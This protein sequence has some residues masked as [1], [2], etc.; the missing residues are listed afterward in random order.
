[1]YASPMYMHI[2]ISCVC[3]EYH[4]LMVTTQL[5]SIVRAIYETSPIIKKKIFKFTFSVTLGSLAIPYYV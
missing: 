3:S 5:Q 4:F 2:L 1:M